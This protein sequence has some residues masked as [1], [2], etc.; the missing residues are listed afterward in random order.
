VTVALDLDLT[1]ELRLE[2]LAREVVRAVQDARKA[3]GLD[4]ADRIDLGLRASGDAARAI[5]AHR[6]WITGEV[7][8]VSLGEPRADGHRGRVEIDG[9]AVEIWLRRAG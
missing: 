4:V 6:A 1:E 9:A 3:A 8:A 5:E 2:G 7:L